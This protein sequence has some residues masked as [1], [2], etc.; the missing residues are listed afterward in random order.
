V[1]DS[2][3]SCA[4][5]AGCPQPAL[6]PLNRVQ[7][8]VLVRIRQLDAAGEVTLRLREMGLGEDQEVRLL[9]RASNVIC[10][11]CNTRLG[12]SHQLAERILVEPVPPVPPA[13]PPALA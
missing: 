10:Q 1:N 7:V 2:T 8:G 3:P 5:T 6:C 11:V 12:L 4:A 13:C 9:S